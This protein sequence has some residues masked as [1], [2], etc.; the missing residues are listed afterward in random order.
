MWKPGLEKNIDEF[1][2]RMK[3]AAGRRQSRSFRLHSRDGLPKPYARIQ[4]RTEACP[5]ITA[6]WA[7]ILEGRTGVFGWCLCIGPPQAPIHHA[8]VML[9]IMRHR[10]TAYGYDLEPNRIDK[11]TYRL[12]SQFVL[13]NQL[14]PLSDFAGPPATGGDVK[15]F[16]FQVDGI[17]RPDSGVYIK[18]SRMKQLVAPL[19]KPIKSNEVDCSD[20][21]ECLDDCLLSDKSDSSVAVASDVE[22]SSDS[23]IVSEEENEAI[24]LKK[25]VQPQA[26]KM[27]QRQTV[28][29]KVVQRQADQVGSL[30]GQPNAHIP[31]LMR[32]QPQA[33]SGASEMIASFLAPSRPCIAMATSALGIGRMHIRSAALYIQSFMGMGP[34]VLEPRA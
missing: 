33:A 9:Y 11:I 1:R 24:N 34:W 6:G 4:P 19:K 12:D 22:F 7:H 25:Q 16:E 14:Q 21:A 18:L 30:A 23:N 31:R 27:V 26:E 3:E 15:V 8:C 20:S 13:L 17:A 29:R 28:K 32:S 10:G 5:P 2:L